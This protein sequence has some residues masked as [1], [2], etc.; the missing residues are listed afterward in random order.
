[1]AVAIFTIRRLLIAFTA[2]LAFTVV[3]P[4]TAR[5]ETPMERA[6]RIADEMNAT[7]SLLAELDVEIRAAQIQADEAQAIIDSLKTHVQETAIQRY[8]NNDQARYD[9][10]NPDFDLQVR[11]RALFEIA[12][13][14]SQ[15][16]IEEYS[17]AYNDL[18]SLE[19]SLIE[20]KAEKEALLIELEAQIDA[21]N[22]EFKRLSDA[23]YYRSVPV[24]GMVCPVLGPVAFSDTWGAPRSGGRSHKGVDMMSP[25]G[26]PTVAPVDGTVVHRDSGLGGMSWGVTGEN[27]DYYYGAH[28]SAYENV[29]IGIVTAGT[30][31]GYVGQTGNARYT[32]PH[33]HFEIH[34]AGGAAINPY[35][36][37]SESC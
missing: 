35:P 4:E 20:F 9:F 8:V 33:L 15:D 17:I 19:K 5:S 11:A 30:I 10:T 14:D 24:G 6:G 36:Y 29:G 26:T 31:I 1:V 23:G 3:A 27:G 32:A 22:K 16:A 21:L 2:I 18:E 25:T 12:T 13:Q 37:V 7:E 28:L 34:P